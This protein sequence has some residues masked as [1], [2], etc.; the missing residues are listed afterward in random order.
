MRQTIDV[1]YFPIYQ[2]SVLSPSFLESHSNFGLVTQ[3]WQS[4][5]LVQQSRIFAKVTRIF[6]VSF[7][8]SSYMIMIGKDFDLQVNN[9]N[10]KKQQEF[11][12]YC[13]N[14]HDLQ[15]TCDIL[16]DISEYTS[17]FHVSPVKRKRTSNP[18]PSNFQQTHYL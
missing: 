14:D 3:L 13:C 2:I 4:F 18:Q 10:C 5:A 16:C 12:Y 6:M 11:F 7:K 15:N 17:I 9:Y 1:Q 8:S